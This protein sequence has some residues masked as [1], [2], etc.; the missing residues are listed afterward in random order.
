MPALSVELKGLNELQVKFDG[1]GDKLDLTAILDQAGAII[2]A[3]IRA[4]FLSQQAPDGSIWPVSKAALERKKSG[5]DGGT[6]FDTGTLFHSIQLHT[7]GEDARAITAS[8][9][10]KEG[11]YY[12]SF[13]QWG[14]VRLPP[15]V[16]LAFSDEDKQVV[17]TFL[18]QE[19]DKA[20][21]K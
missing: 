21:A 10:N 2:L 16:F 13:L 4:R 9:Q 20:F 1:L 14:T 12:G 6:L 5:R 18:K 11:Q 7:E 15:R 17:E 8:A 19:F 3:R